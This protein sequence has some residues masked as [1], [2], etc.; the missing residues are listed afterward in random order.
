MAYVILFFVLYF[1]FA[2]EIQAEEVQ[3][4]V[5]LMGAGMSSC[6]KWTES[7]SIPQLHYQVKQW[8]LGFISGSNWAR[9]EIQVT[10]PDEQA[11]VA[12]V[13]KYCKNN[14]LQRVSSAAAIL[15]ESLQH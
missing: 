2:I 6:G 11:V 10:P 15:I 4:Q 3:V 12:F 7:K 5:F 8:V 1:P 9:D 13:D 14:P